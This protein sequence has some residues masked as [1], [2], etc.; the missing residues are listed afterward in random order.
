ME[1]VLNLARHSRVHGDAGGRQYLEGIGADASGNDGLHPSAGNQ[2]SR[3]HAGAPSRTAMGIFQGFK[4]I[5]LR[6]GNEE[7][8][9]SSETGI[10][11]AIQLRL[12]RR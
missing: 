3:R 5:T 7:I 6:I 1:S 2:L 11:V 9:T 8:P 12:K 4:I 10:D